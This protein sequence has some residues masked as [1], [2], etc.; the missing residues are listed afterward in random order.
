MHLIIVLVDIYSKL[1]HLQANLEVTDNYV[2]LLYKKKLMEYFILVC[3]YSHSC[4]MD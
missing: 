2:G 3:T 4:V 1:L